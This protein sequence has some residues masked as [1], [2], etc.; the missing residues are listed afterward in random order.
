[1]LH[2]LEFRC[3]LIPDSNVRILVVRVMGAITSIEVVR[4]A[5]FLALLPNGAYPAVRERPVLSLYIM[6]RTDNVRG[7]PSLEQHHARAKTAYCVKILGYVGPKMLQSRDVFGLF[8]HMDLG[9]VVRPVS[10]H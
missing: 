6:Q 8:N 2:L 10:L 7:L 9:N 3:T 4:D 5:K 1:M